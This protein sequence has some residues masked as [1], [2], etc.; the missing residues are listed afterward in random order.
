[1]PSRQNTQGKEESERKSIYRKEGKED[2][3]CPLNVINGEKNTLISAN[4]TV[5]R[6]ESK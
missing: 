4:N 3:P 2:Y 6:E 1:L 5:N